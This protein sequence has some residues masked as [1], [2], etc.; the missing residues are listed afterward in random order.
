MCQRNYFNVRIWGKSISGGTEERPIWALLAERRSY[1]LLFCLLARWST[2][3]VNQSWA[4]AISYAFQKSLNKASI[5]RMR[6]IL[7]LLLWIFSWNWWHW[8]DNFLLNN[9]VSVYKCLE[10]EYLECISFQI[11]QYL[12][13]YYMGPWQNILEYLTVLYY[14]ID[15]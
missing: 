14:L 4:K 7:N 1:I 10:K 8:F 9:P 12:C 15:L 2:L 11:E 6:S 5:F 3:L 13:V